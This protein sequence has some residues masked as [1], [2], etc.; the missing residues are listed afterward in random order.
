MFLS[1]SH[2]RDWLQ[3]ILLLKWT[4]HQ[5]SVYDNGNSVYVLKCLSYVSV[6][7]FEKI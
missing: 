3:D 1:S 7:R 2:N 6:G 5:Q 4:K